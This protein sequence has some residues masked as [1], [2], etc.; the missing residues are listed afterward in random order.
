MLARGSAGR[1]GGGEGA[2]VDEEGPKRPSRSLAGP[3]GAG[4]EDAESSPK[5][6]MRSDLG[7]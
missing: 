1:D 2:D 3:V 4:A 5:K 6:S 7:L